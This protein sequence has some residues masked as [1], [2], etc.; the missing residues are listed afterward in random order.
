MASHP[1]K[2]KGRPSGLAEARDSWTALTYFAPDCPHGARQL[3]LADKLETVVGFVAVLAVVETVNL[4]LSR[5]ADA[6]CRL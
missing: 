6:D 5:N 2:P 3:R 4:F 1:P